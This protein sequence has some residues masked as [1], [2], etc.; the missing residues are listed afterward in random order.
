MQCVYKSVY[1]DEA[2]CQQEGIEKIGVLSEED[3][4]RR[5]LYMTFE[6]NTCPPRMF[7]EIEKQESL[8]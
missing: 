6:I 5:V 2:T 7:E 3:N 1:D 4:Y 8:L